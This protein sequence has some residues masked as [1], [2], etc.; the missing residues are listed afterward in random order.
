M[1][2][3]IRAHANDI[4]AGFVAESPEKLRRIVRYFRSHLGQFAP[5]AP[6]C[7]APWRYRRRAVFCV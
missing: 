1:E 6:R 4:A 7:N 3:F 2:A 5:V